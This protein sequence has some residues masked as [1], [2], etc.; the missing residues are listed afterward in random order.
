[1]LLC[2]QVLGVRKTTSNI[3][4]L[5][6]LGRL[7]FKIYIETQMFKYLQRFPFFR[8][9]TYLCKVINE[10]IKITNSRRIA[11]LKYILDSYGL[12]NLMINIFR[13]IEGDI[14]N[15]DYKNRHNFFQKRAKDCLIKEIFALL[16]L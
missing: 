16:T 3:Q 14:S 1:M 6:E 10:E 13:V 5:A 2:N 7:P 15:K 12:S 9:N 11:Y 4:A 8:E